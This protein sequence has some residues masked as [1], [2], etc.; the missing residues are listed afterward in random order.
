MSE[1]EGAISVERRDHLLLIGLNR[2]SKYNGYTPTSLEVVVGS[3]ITWTNTGALPHT[4]T[5][6]AGAFDSGLVLAGDTYTRTFTT[7]A[8][9]Q[10]FCTIHPEMVATLFVVGAVVGLLVD[11]MLVQYVKEMDPEQYPYYAFLPPYR[12]YY[13]VVHWQELMAYV[14]VEMIVAIPLLVNTYLVYHFD[15]VWGM[16]WFDF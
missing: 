5:D 14:V 10:Y 9:Y 16:G 2:P 8:T 7:A 4:V 1:D 12:V 3:T 6:V 15:Q 13:W 11:I